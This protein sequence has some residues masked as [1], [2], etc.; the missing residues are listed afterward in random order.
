MAVPETYSFLSAPNLHDEP[1]TFFFVQYFHSLTLPTSGT[2][3]AN[4]KR[5]SSSSTY[6]AF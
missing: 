4:E 6:T 3:V 1:L 5:Y 2:P